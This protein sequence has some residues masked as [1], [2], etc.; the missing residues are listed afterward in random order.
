MSERTYI[1]ESGIENKIVYS[2]DIM[3]KLVER[4]Y[5]PIG[6]MPNPINP[7]YNCWIFK[8]SEKLQEDLD[9]I[10][11]EKERNGRA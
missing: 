6:M 5:I 10:F 9:K 3:R 1:P 11:E 8:W 2:V 4:N 7:K